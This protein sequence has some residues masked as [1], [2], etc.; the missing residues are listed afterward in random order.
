MSKR[1][2][3]DVTDAEIADYLAYQLEDP[4]ETLDAE[5]NVQT[6]ADVY[7]G[8]IARILQYPTFTRHSVYARRSKKNKKQ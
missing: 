2:L 8:E 7:F 3:S 5:I 6:P 4:D 1:K